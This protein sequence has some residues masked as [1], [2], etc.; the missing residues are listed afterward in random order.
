MSDTQ[1]IA[2]GGFARINPDND[3]YC[4][5]CRHYPTPFTNLYLCA[6]NWRCII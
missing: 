3:V 6:R 4:D 5:I 2:V 1:P